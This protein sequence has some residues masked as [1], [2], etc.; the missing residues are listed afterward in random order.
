MK[1][2]KKN[3][4]DTK[5]IFVYGQSNGARVA[6]MLPSVVSDPSHIRG[7]LAEGMPTIGLPYKDAIVPT[8]LYYGKRIHGADVT[9][10]ISCGHEYGES[11]KF[12]LKTGFPSKMKM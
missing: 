6:L 10:K 3:H 9:T 1:F 11:P 5:N 12:L 2:V 7:V 4:W 8:R